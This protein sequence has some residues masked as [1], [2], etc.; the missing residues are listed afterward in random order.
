MDAA[1][2]LPDVSPRPASARLR[3]ILIFAVLIAVRVD[4]QCADAPTLASLS[5][6]ERAERKAVL[7]FG[8]WLGGT[9]SELQARFGAPIHARGDSTRYFNAAPIDSAF[10]WHY[11]AFA[12]SL[13]RNGDGGELAS[14][15]ALLAP[16][17]GAPVSVRLQHAD[18]ALARRLLGSGGTPVIR[19]DTLEVCVPLTGV[20]DAEEEVHL[21]FIRGHL[22]RALWS[23]YTG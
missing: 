4:A 17:A 23:F 6:A 21:R 9:R 16:M 19:G 11:H 12:V 7:A 14:H 10:E 20:D 8:H 15:V 2:A 13:V 18:T 3:L 1:T 22:V 5:A